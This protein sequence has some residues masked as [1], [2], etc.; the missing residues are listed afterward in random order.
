MAAGAAVTEVGGAAAPFL[1]PS[2]A[3]APRSPGR[4]ET[5][6]ASRDVSPEGSLDGTPPATAAPGQTGNGL[7]ATICAADT[8]CASAAIGNTAKVGKTTETG[9][10]A[11]KRA[12]LRAFRR[13]CSS[14]SRLTKT[15]IKNIILPRMNAPR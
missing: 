12:N 10:C 11:M 3:R 1:E 9:A 13:I 6:G 15:Y 14:D 8:H 4:S 5:P 7:P 2:A